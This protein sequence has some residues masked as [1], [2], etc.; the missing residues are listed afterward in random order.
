[1]S[2]SLSVGGAVFGGGGEGEGEED[3]PG[4]APEEEEEEGRGDH[5][6]VAAVE[7]EH[8][9]EE[10]VGAVGDGGHVAGFEGGQAGGA[11]DGG[12][13]GLQEGVGDGGGGGAGE[14]GGGS[15]KGCRRERGGVSDVVVVIDPGRRGAM[16]RHFLPYL[17]LGE[18][19]GEIRVG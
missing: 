8:V 12:E 1:M 6:E 2:Q 14:F 9:G 7:G 15:W 10:V 16:V 5:G 17:F 19:F 18:M 11:E 3:L 4:E 13:G